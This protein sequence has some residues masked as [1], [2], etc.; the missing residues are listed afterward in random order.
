MFYTGMSV[1]IFNRILRVVSYANG[2]T[3]R[4]YE[5]D[6][7]ILVVL[8]GTKKLGV[9]VGLAQDNGFTICSL[10]TIHLTLASSAALPAS[11]DNVKAG[12]D[13]LVAIEL[14]GRQNVVRFVFKSSFLCSFPFLS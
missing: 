7:A 10:K 13:T 3:R 4:Y 9:V 1:N 14:R 8:R 11:L 5:A 6:S 2:A 12:T